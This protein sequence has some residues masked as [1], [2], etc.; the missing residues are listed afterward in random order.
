MARLRAGLAD[1]Y[2]YYRDG[3]QMMTRIHHDSEVVPPVVVA[4]RKA[5][6]Q[7]WLVT[8]LQ[9]FP[10]SPQE[11][12]AAVGHAT[13]FSTWL[14]LCSAQDLSDGLAI[15]LMVG[16]VAGAAEAGGQSTA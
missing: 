15:D 9:P 1:I 13:A 16:M 11:V 5:R 4:N 6:E 3:E 2:R 10:A 12:R 8:L 14:S 7:Q